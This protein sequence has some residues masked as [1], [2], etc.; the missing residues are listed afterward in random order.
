MAC[1]SCN[2]C[3][4]NCCKELPTGLAACEA[5]NKYNNEEIKPLIC[6][7]KVIDPCVSLLD[8]ISSHLEKTYC[9]FSNIINNLCVMW[10][11]LLDNENKVTVTETYAYT[12]PVTKFIRITGEDERGI[13][14]SG[15]PAEGESYISIPV[16]NM[17][18]VDAV[19][20]Q[21]QVVGGKT[22]PVTCAIQ[23]NYREGDNYIVNFDVYIIEGQTVGGVPSTYAPFAVPVV[24]TVVGKRDIGKY[25]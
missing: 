20:A 18:E 15:S 1:S 14:F 21:V 4:N 12:V 13:W 16:S 2:S 10:D 19:S 6:M 9:L 5:L 7:A 3:C 25:Q 24:F 22:H 11:V 17:D 8:F 23:Q